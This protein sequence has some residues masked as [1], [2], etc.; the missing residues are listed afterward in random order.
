[1]YAYAAV[2]A[3]AV[4]T[5]S[6]GC[7][8]WFARART[9]AW[10]DAVG[11]RATV[12]AARDADH[13]YVLAARSTWVTIVLGAVAVS[14]WAGRVV[15]NARSRGMPVSPRKA[16]WMWFIPLFG[17]VPSIRELRKSVSGTDYSTHRLSRWLVTL[18][19]VTFMHVFFFLAT[20]TANTTT[21]E[22]LAALE[23]ESL[24]AT[25]MFVAY[26]IATA[27]AASAI[28]HAD[29]ALTLRRRAP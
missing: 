11:R 5:L 6:T 27:F 24:F 16:R 25:L 21:P 19:V 17:I 4:Y 8:A 2:A 23:R 15:A 22:A 10:A 18:Y 14:V 3:F 12:D 9:T 7:F 28:L 26:A 1:M 29:K 20:G 13:L